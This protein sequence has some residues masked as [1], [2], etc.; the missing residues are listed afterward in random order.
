MSPGHFLTTS[1]SVSI[2]Q[3]TTHVFLS[4]YVL[5]TTLTSIFLTFFLFSEEMILLA[6]ILEKKTAFSSMFQPPIKE[7]SNSTMFLMLY[8]YNNVWYVERKRR[9]SSVKY[10]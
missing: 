7:E 9:N 1:I 8:G 6:I 10:A 5:L 3:L 4:I 2:L